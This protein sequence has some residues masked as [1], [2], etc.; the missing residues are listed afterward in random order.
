MDWIALL[1]L[2]AWLARWRVLLAEGAIAAEDRL[3]LAQLEWVE[4][5]H[6]LRR[7]VVCGLVVTAI[8]VV[9]LLLLSLALL[10]QFW[11]SP[12]RTLVAWLLAGGWTVVWIA[13]VL[14]LLSAVR[15]TDHAFA[16]TRQELHKD[17]QVFVHKN[18]P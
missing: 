6:H 5:K 14:V 9:A 8:T 1:G 17:W 3:A 7:V 4:H 12:Q 11:D 16:L 13:S 2:D 10:V 15:R 18:Q